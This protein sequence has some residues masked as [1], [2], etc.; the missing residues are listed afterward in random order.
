M[1]LPHIVIVTNSNK[2][3]PDNM[4]S[5]KDLFG[6]SR[7]QHFAITGCNLSITDAK[8]VSVED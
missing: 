4:L 8:C 1:G 7:L 5:L 6:V 3:G 2:D